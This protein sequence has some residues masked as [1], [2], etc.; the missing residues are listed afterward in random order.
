MSGRFFPAIQS[1]KPT[2]SVEISNLSCEIL[3]DLV[4]QF[5]CQLEK[6]EN[7]KYYLSFLFVL[8]RQ[9]PLKADMAVVLDATPRGGLKAIKFVNLKVRVCDALSTIKS[10]PLVSSISEQIAKCSNLP[11]RCPVKA[12]ILYNI[13]NMLIDK[14][15]IPIY[16]PSLD[17]NFTFR[18][19][20]QNT[21][22]G[23]VF[24]YGSVKRLG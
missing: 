4:K 7:S 5:T 19:L 8:R 14:D 11:L 16:A 24:V 1:K 6:L 9:L 13:S 20:E 15:I 3:D 23:N 12:N 10:N 21:K 17:Y 18:F 2:F 22:Y